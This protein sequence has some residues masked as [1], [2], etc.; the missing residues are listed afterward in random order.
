MKR[1]NKGRQIPEEVG[2]GRTS[3]KGNSRQAAV[4]RT[5]SRS[6]HV[7]PNAGCASSAE[8]VKTTPRQTLDSKE[9]PGALF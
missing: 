6:Y 4:A 9:E 5:L 1:S 8:R 7:D 3:A 2:E